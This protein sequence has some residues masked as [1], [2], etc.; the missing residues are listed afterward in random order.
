MKLQKEKFNI[1]KHSFIELDICQIMCMEKD[2]LISSSTNSTYF[3]FL[4]C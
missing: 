2:S 3:K 1:N 4:C